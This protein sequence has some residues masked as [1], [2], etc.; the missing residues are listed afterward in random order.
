V[1]GLIQQLGTLLHR[2]AISGETIS[3]SD[4]NTARVSENLIGLGKQRL[5]RAGRAG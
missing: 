3:I 5:D 2:H 4:I 1:I